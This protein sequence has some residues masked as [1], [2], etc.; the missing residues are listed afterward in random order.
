M[1]IFWAWLTTHYKLN[2]HHPL[3]PPKEERSS[4]PEPITIHTTQN[5]VFVTWEWYQ[6]S[7][8]TSFVPF[9]SL[10]E[11]AEKSNCDSLLS[12]F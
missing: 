11:M 5:D 12:D 8:G 4:F 10:L 1:A 6:S 7:I 9:V 2:F 3:G